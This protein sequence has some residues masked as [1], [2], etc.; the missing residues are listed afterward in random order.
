MTN[1]THLFIKICIPYTLFSK[2]LMFLWCIRNEWRRGQTAILTQ[3]LFLTIAR[4]IIF[5]NPLSNSCA[6]WLGLLNR[7][8]LRATA[9]SLEGDPH[10]GL[11]ITTASKAAGICRYSF[12]S[13]TSFRFFLHLFT[14]VHLWLTARSRVNIQ[15]RE[16]LHIWIIANWYTRHKNCNELII[17]LQ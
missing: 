1:E 4:S 17:K 13:P 9:L 16:G 10:S 14:L 15:H 12:I 7:G 8:S 2:G 3:L 6:S 11:P 5:K